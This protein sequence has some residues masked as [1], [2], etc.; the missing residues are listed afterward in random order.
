MAAVRY[1]RPSENFK[2]SGYLVTD[3]LF[4]LPVTNVID[5]IFMD[6]W[7]IIRNDSQSNLLSK[8]FAKHY[9]HTI[10]CNVFKI[11]ISQK[12]LCAGD[13]KNGHDTYKITVTG[14]LAPVVHVPFHLNIQGL[15]SIGRGICNSPAYIGQRPLRMRKRL[16]LPQPLGP[17]INKCMPGLMHRFKDVTTTSQLGVTTGTDRNNIHAFS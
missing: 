12:H 6:G 13:I 11:P 16:D 3:S 15:S 9:N 10:Y 2:C 1:D 7:G 8:E 4:C 14:V 17:V 5:K